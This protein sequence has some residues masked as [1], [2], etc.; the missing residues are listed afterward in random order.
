MKGSFGTMVTAALS[1]ILS[2][3]IAPTRASIVTIAPSRHLTL[4]AQT[5]IGADQ[6]ISPVQNYGE[7]FAIEIQPNAKIDGPRA[8][9]MALSHPV[10]YTSSQ[11]NGSLSSWD[12]MEARADGFAA[13]DRAGALRLISKQPFSSIVNEVPA[14]VAAWQ[15][16]ATLSAL[17][18]ARLLVRTQTP[19]RIR[20]FNKN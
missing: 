6:Q 14:P 4:G 12:E 20:T 8:G 15:I 3:Q 11:L 1:L 9:M 2:F 17:G 13:D 18:L 19:P 7:R 16:L 5:A 10:T